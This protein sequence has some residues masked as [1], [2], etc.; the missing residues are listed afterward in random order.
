VVSAFYLPMRQLTP[1]RLGIASQLHLRRLGMGRAAAPPAPARADDEDASGTDASILAI[2]DVPE[3][4]P[5][6]E[7]QV[8]GSTPTPP[9]AAAAA[10]EAPVDLIPGF[11]IRDLIGQSETSSVYL[12]GS[13]RFGEPV[14][15][16]V[17]RTARDAVAGQ[18]FM[19]REYTAITQIHSRSVVAI[20]DYG[21]HE[22]IEYLVMEYLPRGN[23]KARMQQGLSEGEALHYAQAVARALKVIHDAGVLHRDLKP[24]NVLLRED[25]DVALIDFGQARAV[26]GTAPGGTVHGS[27][28]YMSPEHALGEHLD[29]RSDLYSLGVVL[30]EMLAGRRPYTGSSA[31]EVLQQHVSAP[32]PQLPAEVSRCQGLLNR[33]LAKRRQERCATAAEVIAELTRLRAAVL[34]DMEPSAA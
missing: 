27:P 28:F 19:E 8:A 26:E 31:L 11:V 5:A 30:Y 33:L 9:A 34:A 23:L 2:F 16:K 25:D 22:G 3:A 15:L 10:L 18:Q 17:T 14:A 32:L 7:A 20:H 29:V 13:E 1:L 4:P 12:A 6:P 21:V 24:P